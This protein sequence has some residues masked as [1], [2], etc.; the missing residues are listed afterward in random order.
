ML[1]VLNELKKWL[2][3][4]KLFAF[5]ASSLLLVFEGENGI[6]SS[7]NYNVKMIDFAHVRKERG[8]D[9]GYLYGIGKLMVILKSLLSNERHMSKSHGVEA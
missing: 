6:S 8:G 7:C 5:Y 1:S 2:E 3:E 4:N 9:T